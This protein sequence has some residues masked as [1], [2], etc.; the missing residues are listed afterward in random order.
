VIDRNA[1][2]HRY[3]L[4]HNVPRFNN[5]TGV[6]DNDRY[7]LEVITNQRFTLTSL[8]GGTGYANGTYT[9]TTTGGSGTGMTLTI[10]V[11]GG[12]VTNATILNPGNG[13]VAGDTLTIVGG[14]ND[15]TVD[16]VGSTFESVV[17][18]W[19]GTCA[20]C[21]ELEVVSCTPCS[22]SVIEIP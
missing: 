11:A 19:L 3:Y 12:I 16:L 2:Y 13:Y 18:T 20:Q 7:M 14:N 9:A 21:P 17:N 10:T 22:T 6:F 5:P 8:V 1:R 4:L 15:A